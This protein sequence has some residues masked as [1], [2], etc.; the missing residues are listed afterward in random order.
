MPKATFAY[1]SHCALC[2]QS[3][4][5]NDNLGLAYASNGTRL[6]YALCNRCKAKADK[7]FSP[8]Q[9]ETLDARLEA[10]ST[11]IELARALEAIK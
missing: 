4:K 5:S 1:P 2:G 3:V 11:R 10:A 8:K 9:E 6:F 7:G